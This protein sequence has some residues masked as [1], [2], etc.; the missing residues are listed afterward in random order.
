MEQW[1]PLEGYPGYSAST[2]GRI[3]NDDR[4]SILAVVRV[5]GRRCYVGLMQNNVQVKRS[6]SKL[7]AETFVENERAEYFDTPIHLDGDLTNCAARNLRWRPKWFADRHT[8]QF[9]LDLI[10][11]GP[12]KNINT[13]VIYDG[14]WSIVFEHGV[15]FNDVVAS[16]VNKTW[17]FPLMQCFEWVDP[18]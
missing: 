14:V 17:V 10:D 7:I 15:L 3:R 13:G 18:K 6:L 16:I 9:T 5:A 8:Y 4:D 12:V 1:K 11:V 2:Y